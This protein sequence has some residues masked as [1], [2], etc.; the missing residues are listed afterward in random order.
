MHKNTVKSAALIA[1]A[2][3]V[4]GGLLGAAYGQVQ[5]TSTENFSFIVLGNGQIPATGLNVE[6]QSES[7]A[8]LATYTSTP[9]VNFTAYPGNY[10]IY[11]PAQYVAGEVYNA[12]SYNVMLGQNGNIYY[13]GNV[14][15]EDVVHFEMASSTLTISAT[16]ATQITSVYVT[17]PNTLVL[18]ASLV[19]S[20][21]PSSPYVVS[22]IPGAQLVSVR[23]H[24]GSSAV[25]S[26]S[27]TVKGSQS[28]SV[29]VSQG[30]SVVG[31]VVSTSGS[32]VYNLRISI[33]QGG[34]LLGTDEFS[35][36]YYYV[37]LSPGT[38][39]LVV[40]APGYLPYMEKGVTIVG[41]V[42]QYV[43]VTLK[44]SNLVQTAKFTF[45]STFTSYTMT[46]GITLTNSTVLFTLPYSN[47][48]S[49][50]DQMHLLGLT[51]GQLWAILNYTIQTTSV[52][53]IIFNNYSYNLQTFS[54]TLVPGSNGVMYQF[55]YTAT[56]SQPSVTTSTVNHLQVYANKNAV[57][58]SSISYVYEVGLPSSYQRSNIIE[59]SIADVS[60]YSGVVTISNSSTSGFINIAIKQQT[61]PTLDLAEISANWSGYFE[62]TIM[63]SS[64]NNF[65]L[66]VP[67]D[68]A[69]NLNAS[70]IPYDTVLAVDN[71]NE[72]SFAWTFG[73]S[74][75]ATG[76]NI[77]ESFAAGTY[78]SS[79]KVISSG[80][81]A[82][83]TNFTIIATAQ[84]PM[85]KLS[86]IQNGGTVLN[87]STS[88]STSYDLSVNESQTVYFNAVN[89]E[90]VLPNGQNT[91]LGLILSW[92]ISGSQQSGYNTSFSFTQ[93]TFGSSVE[94]ANVTVEN[95]VGETIVISFTVH[96]KDITPPVATFKIENTQGKVITSSKEYQNITLNGAKSFAPNGGHITL[97][98]W[99]FHYSNG[100]IAKPNVD[101]TVHS[102][103]ANNSSV[104]LSFAGYGNFNIRLQVTDQSGHKGNTSMTLFV[105]AIRPEI[106]IMNITYPNSYVEGS[107]SS[108]TVQLKNVG[109]SNA[110]TYYLT[111]TIDKKVVK[112]ETFSSLAINQTTNQTISFT[113]PNS[114]SYSMIV[115]V[116]AVNQPSFFNTNVQV[117]KA[118]SVSQAAWK[119]PALVGGIVVAIGIVSFVYYDVTVRRKRPKQTKEP[120]RQLKI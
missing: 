39:N 119:L 95:G 99:S 20:S 113:P 23:Y 24:S 69:V 64:A 37:T 87:V 118:I 61:K 7:G 88:S 90:D 56:Y 45:D 57:T 31:S 102:T 114:G 15:T 89:S 111:V 115:K 3:M 33:Y 71:F 59:N 49:L 12:S 17:L 70:G 26:E 25:Y 83:S 106:E 92:D 29:N 55:S 34:Q 30:G 11:I 65:I 9:L 78:H 74:M 53:S 93:P 100:T 117:T 46:A 81:N 44:P 109:L 80:G 47:S 75:N 48:G 54:S 79:L 43:K 19:N 41:S 103:S 14:F 50:Y 107:S 73:S 52:S 2:L 10:V 42:H 38:Y 76:Y 98:N 85:F 66:L 63:N 105:S 13:N 18:T 58:T 110:T 97:Y 72:M 28:I 5:G 32:P 60:G 16:G 62:S 108:L 36:G 101:Y 21:N 116:Y 67:V 94:N 8:V 4:I 82:N 6:L 112:N 84:K 40:S 1:V 91:S 27:I 96:V 77:T 35:N 22:T 86:V 68:K 51:K 120:K 104:T